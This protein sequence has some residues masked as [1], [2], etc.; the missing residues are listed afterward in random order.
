[1]YMISLLCSDATDFRREWDR[2]VYSMFPL[3]P[4]AAIMALAGEPAPLPPGWT[5][6]SDSALRYTRPEEDV[7]CG[8]VTIANDGWTSYVD[9]A[10]I[11]TYKSLDVAMAAVERWAAR[12]RC[13]P[14]QAREG[15]ELARDRLCGCP[16]TPFICGGPRET[17]CT[18]CLVRDAIEFLRGA[19]ETAAAPSK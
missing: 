2:V 7:S 8:A 11:N 1:M 12:G 3:T 10:A 15:L 16:S 13:K 9:Q 6:A 5:Q 14:S 17:W 19:D 18:Y 4:E